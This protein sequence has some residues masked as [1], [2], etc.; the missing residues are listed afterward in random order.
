MNRAA[1]EIDTDALHAYAD[2]QLTAEQNAAVEAYLAEHPDA[3]A[4]V[5]QW[6]RQNDAMRVMFA[7]VAG[8]AV[9]PRLSPHAIDGRLRAGRMQMLRNVAAVFLV[10]T[11]AGSL[12]WYLRGAFWQEEPVSE[13]LI[14]NAVLAHA[15]YVKEKSHAVEAAADSPN[16]MRWLS[17]RIAT[18]I[19]APNLAD[20]GFTFIGGRLLP[21]YNEDGA[22]GPA[23]QLMYENAAAERLTLYITGPLDDK[24]EVWKF[25]N[26]DGVGAYYWANDA[27]T[28]T[29]VASLPENDVHLL[30]KKIFEQLTRK[31]DSSWNPMGG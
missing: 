21:G 12:G 18:P 22:H 29:I 13:R 2:G 15:L 9:P 3:A 23:A 7:P 24:K 16:L 8:E 30:G 14:D 17:N 26:R 28:C 6:Q 31:A 4:L 5:A 20:Q 10:V 19:D 1:F 27:V 11:M 25:E